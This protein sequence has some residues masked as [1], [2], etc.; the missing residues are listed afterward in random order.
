[1]RATI[2]LIMASVAGAVSLIIVSS[3]A[4]PAPSGRA[5]W[6]YQSLVSGGGKAQGGILGNR[7][8]I[9][10]LLWNQHETTKDP[11]TG[12]ER[13][14][15]RPASEVMTTK[16]EH[17]RIVDDRLWNGVQTER[18]KRTI[19]RL[20]DG[21]IAHRP[22]L[23]RGEHLLSGL[24]RCGACNGHMIFTK[25]SRG[26]RYS[27]CSAAHQTSMC[28]HRRSYQVDL[29]Q[30]AASIAIREELADPAEYAR[31]AKLR[32]AEFEEGRRRQ[33]KELLDA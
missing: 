8:Y 19:A 2:S 31:K 5:S 24:L 9:G 29:I 22:V 21:G 17:L 32:A 14:K 18:K 28:S 4:I 30:E 7:L 6:N 12:S 26:K 20:P 10:E 23:Q 16:V 1:M 11:D 25:L 3:S 15:R 27:T 13:R 33:R